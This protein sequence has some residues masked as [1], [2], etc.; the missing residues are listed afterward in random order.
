[1]KKK[2]NRVYQFKIALK[3]VKPMIWRRIEVPET[4]SFWDLHVAIQ[5]A[6]G[7]EDDHLHQFELVNPTTGIKTEIGIPEEDSLFGGEILPGWKEKIAEWFSMENKL[8]EYTYDFGDD[9]QHTVRL[10]KIL[11]RESSVKYP[12]CVGGKRACPP[13]D[14]GGIWG[15][16]RLLEIINDKNH[17]EHEGMMEWLGGEFDPEYFDE[18]KVIFMDPNKRRRGALE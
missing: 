11:P 10:E 5:D 18:E 2:F 17:E 1:M 16:A 12:R 8:A 7:W 14:C 6:M 15:Y 13:E 3:G 4:Y 9:W